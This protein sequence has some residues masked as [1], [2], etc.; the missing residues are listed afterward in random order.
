MPG[1]M[2]GLNARHG[3]VS[4]VGSLAASRP[5]HTLGDLPAKV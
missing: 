3:T 4:L 5:Y 2:V 1:V